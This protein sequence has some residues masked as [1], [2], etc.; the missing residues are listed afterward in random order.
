MSLTLLTAAAA[1]DVAASKPTCYML[2]VD[3]R[4][5][6]LFD[7]P[8]WVRL[9]PPRDGG[10]LFVHRERELMVVRARGVL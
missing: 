7:A 10:A 2:C 6:E 5:A 8:G 9:D 4:E 1:R 3:Q